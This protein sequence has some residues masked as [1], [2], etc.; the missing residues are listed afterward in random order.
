VV[1]RTAVEARD[2]Y[3][4]RCYVTVKLQLNDALPEVSF[5][6]PRM[7]QGVTNL[8]SNAATFSGDDAEI[9]VITTRADGGVRIEVRAQD[10]GILAAQH[11]EVFERFSS[12]SAQRKGKMPGTGLGLNISR[13]LVE[14]H[15]GKIWFESEEAKGSTFFVTLPG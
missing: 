9:Q 11:A 8:V 15:G 12:L 5:D 10:S 3:V 1:V 7:I 6:E 2:D 4:H 13:R 14:M